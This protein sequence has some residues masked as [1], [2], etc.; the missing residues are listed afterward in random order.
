MEPLRIRK[1]IYLPA[2]IVVILLKWDLTP[3]EAWTR[4]HSAIVGGGLEV[5][6]PF[7]IDWIHVTMTLKTGDDKSP[8]AMPQTTVPLEDGYLLRNRHHMLTRHLPRLDPSLQ[9]FHGFLI[10]T[11]I[12]EVVVELRRDR[13]V[14]ALSHKADKE[15][16]I[17]DLLDNLT[18]FFRLGHV[19]S[20]KDPPPY[21]SNY[22]GP[23]SVN[24]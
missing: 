15:K 20:H 13:E 11:H 9:R 18:Y 14:K 7:K 24:I 23:R 22:Q 1:T 17:P 10:T 5:D 2:P 21:G 6:C 4:L 16:G 8:L 3:A 12:R 19:E